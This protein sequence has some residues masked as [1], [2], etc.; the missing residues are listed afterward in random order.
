MAITWMFY[1]CIRKHES[2]GQRALK[3]MSIS[4]NEEKEAEISTAFV[5][6]FFSKTV[7]LDE[8]GRKNIEMI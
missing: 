7:E 6:K 5:N 4:L 2:L 8:K 1:A 3:A